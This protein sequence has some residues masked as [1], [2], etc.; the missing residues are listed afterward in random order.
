MKIK[1]SDLVL[2]P[3]LALHPLRRRV[4]FAL[5]HEYF[6]DLDLFIPLSHDLA[7]PLV[8]EDDRVSLSEIFFGGEYDSLATHI[9]L[10]RRWIDLGCNAGYFSL[11]LEWQRRKAGLSVDSTALLV[12]ADPRQPAAIE[13]LFALNHLGSRWAFTLGLIAPGDGR[14][15]F[16]QRRFM[17]SSTQPDAS[18]PAQ[19]VSIETLT[20]GR[21]RTQFPPPYDLIKVDIEGAETDFWEHYKALWSETKS[22]LLEW[23][24]PSPGPETWRTR[25]RD[26]GFANVRDFLPS[27]AHSAAMAG[28]AGVLLATRS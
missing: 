11:W 26:G 1:F 12:D 20:P 9:E 3:L 17:A 18:N 25:L 6:A 14:Q 8:H 27:T 15:N 23:H 24:G 5:R 2:K 10:P 13:R 4:A 16:Y 21:L 7:C 28:Q 19:S 22:L